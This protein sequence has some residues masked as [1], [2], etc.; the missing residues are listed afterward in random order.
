MLGS[1][2]VFISRL[3]CVFWGAETK[4]SE[5]LI[6]KYLLHKKNNRT[7][8]ARGINLK[9]LV[10]ILMKTWITSTNVFYRDDMVNRQRSKYNFFVFC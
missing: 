10:F 4:N 8:S 2:N 1:V 5:I 9:N 7:K 3:T 6:V